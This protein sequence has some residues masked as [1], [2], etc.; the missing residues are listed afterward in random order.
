MNPFFFW[1]GARG[2]VRYGQWSFLTIALMFSLISCAMILV[3]VHW[4]GLLPPKMQKASYVAYGLTWL[5]LSVMSSKIERKIRK[6]HQVPPPE[7]DIFHDAQMHYLQGNWFETECCLNMLLKRN[8]RDADALLMLATLF[9]RTLRID[10][11][12][13]LM[14]RLDLLEERAAWKQEIRQEKRQIMRVIAR[15]KKLTPASPTKA[16]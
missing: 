1:P 10:E 3:H 15:Q 2:I 8:P 12:V 16:A 5:A 9:R 11:A 14:K 4:T 6:R 13:H 7:K